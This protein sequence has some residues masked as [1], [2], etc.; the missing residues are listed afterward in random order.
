MSWRA[1]EICK[2]NFS[3]KKFSW[4]LHSL[5]HV[6]DCDSRYLD[7]KDSC[8]FQRYTRSCHTHKEA[9]DGIEEVGKEVNEVEMKEEEAEEEKRQHGRVSE[10]QILKC[11]S[12]ISYRWQSKI[13]PTMS[14]CLV[15]SYQ[16][17]LWLSIIS[18]R[19]FRCPHFNILFA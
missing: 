2:E 10:D 7:I 11:I 16:S 8:E 17:S 19:P 3:G 9:G 5:E 13:T 18:R 15:F 12:N 1:G 14:K 4:R 6:S